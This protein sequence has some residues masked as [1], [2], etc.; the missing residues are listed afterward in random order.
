MA[1]RR[2]KRRP[3]G[4]VTGKPSEDQ[5][6]WVL[7]FAEA[8]LSTLELERLRQMGR[9]AIQMT[10]EEAL[11][12]SLGTLASSLR[13]TSGKS[14][15][16]RWIKY[17]RSHR[18]T[19][20]Q[21]GMLLEVWAG[22]STFPRYTRATLKTLQVEVR[23]CLRALVEGEAWPLPEVPVKEA[24]VPAVSDVGE[25]WAGRADDTSRYL[26]RRYHGTFAATFYA[27]IRDVL[28]VW[29]ER[30]RLCEAPTCRRLFIRDDPRR[31]FCSPGCLQDTTW[32]KFAPTR[33]RDYKA[34]Y[35]ARVVKRHG[36]KVKP[37]HR[38]R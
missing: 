25:H 16:D 11:G 32:K 29:W 7:G 21:N 17:R 34:E 35:A 38:V 33:V 20:S 10:Q 26:V 6:R 22:D 2:R 14:S 28:V 18:R 37:R 1:R 4:S 9:D 23:E 12:I 24:I 5:M 30:L 36:P 8:D 3:V 31:R 13:H 27:A 19:E 15:K